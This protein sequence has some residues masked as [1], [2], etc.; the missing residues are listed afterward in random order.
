VLAVVASL[1]IPFVDK[2]DGMSE[3]CFEY[4]LTVMV[5]E[6]VYK[7]M[8]IYSTGD[9]HDVWGSMFSGKYMTSTGDTTYQKLIR[10]IHLL[11]IYLMFAKRE[12]IVKLVLEHQMIVDGFYGDDNLDSYPAVMDNFCYYEDSENFALDYVNFCEREFGLVNKKSEFGIY[13]ELYSTHCFISDG[14]STLLDAFYMG[15]TF[16]R[17]SVSHVYLDGLY[18]GDFPYRDT[19]DVMSKVGRVLTASSSMAMTMCLVASLAR[20]CSGN[21][22]AYDHLS[23]IYAELL[24]VNGRVTLSEWNNFQ[25]QKHSNSLDRM[26]L[27]YCDYDGYNLFPSIVELHKIQLAGYLSKTGLNPCKDGSFYNCDNLF[28]NNGKPTDL[29]FGDNIE[30]VPMFK[31]KLA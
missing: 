9:L 22:E 16:I 25:T 6:V 11:L 4:I 26:K 2:P 24:A 8:Y 7:T 15:P 5:T 13:D 31:R 29:L 19:E 27:E 10:P 18:V 21:L 17:N 23:K 20:L 28:F 14:D 1:I 12:P 30:D 3:E